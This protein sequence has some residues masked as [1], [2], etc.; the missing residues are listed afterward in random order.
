MKIKKKFI[1]IKL[2]FTLIEILIAVT[3]IALLVVVAFYMA[4]NQFLKAR[5]AKRK[6][7]VVKIQEAVEEYEKDH[8]CYPLP[9]LVTCEPGNDL[10]PYLSKVPCDP[11]TGGSYYYEND[12]PSCPKWYRVYLALE[13]TNDSDLIPAIGP[14]GAYNFY[15]G[16]ANAPAP[17]PSATPVPTQSPTPTPA[18]QE[19]VFYGCKSG[20]CVKLGWDPA[21][22]GP[23]CDPNYQNP[24]CYGQCGSPVNECTEW[25]P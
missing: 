4:R 5:D 13:N 3:I 11:A 9:Q 21:R 20:V 2:G 19:P 1:P 10:L 22:P 18:L 14:S 17:L 6:S 7:D 15:L 8:D 24:N 23:D 16:S 25:N 12:N